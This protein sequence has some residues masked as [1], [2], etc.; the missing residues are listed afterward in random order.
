MTSTPDWFNV[1]TYGADPTGASD[2][3]S[4]I[5]TAVS[6][7][8]SAGGGVV[9]F[10]TGSFKTSGFSIAASNISI[11]GDGQ[12]ASIIRLSSTT[13]NCITLGASGTNYQ[14]ISIKGIT[15]LPEG[16]Q[17]GGAQIYVIDSSVIRISDLWAK[18]YN[19]IVIDSTQYESTCRIDNFYMQSCSNAGICIG[20]SSASTAA[21]V[22]TYISNGTIAQCGTGLLIQNG[23][24][25][26]A[27]AVD[28]L[29][30]SS[31]VSLNPASNQTANSCFFNQVLTDTQTGTGWTLGGSGNL[32]EII[33][34]SCWAASSSGSSGINITNSSANGIL[35]ENC[36]V[37]NNYEY[38][39][40]IS[41][42]TNINIS[43]N[44]V[45]MN[46]T[47]GSGTYHGIAVAPNLS[48]FQITGNISGKGG[49]FSDVGNTNNQGYGIIVNSGSSNNYIIQ[50]NRCPSNV[51]GG[52]SD[53][54]TGTLKYVGNN[55]SS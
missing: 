50:N 6:D 52:V 4:A 45:F 17:T 42:G 24:G 35:I 38:G 18:G 51:T 26:Y 55:L 10:P 32:S 37:H 29:K 43:N 53:A 44:M 33:M 14:N 34:N 25:V 16:T 27:N 11:L 49:Y 40:I 8:T 47:I 1:V 20:P 46:S 19:G 36:N 9:Y 31:G 22:D 15:L 39:I 3:T 21:P 5:T 54:G 23:S 12:G 7:A 13:A 41:A 30:G 2:S 28:I 48:G